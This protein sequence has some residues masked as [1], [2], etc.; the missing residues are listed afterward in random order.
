LKGDTFE[1]KKPLKSGIFTLLMENFKR[2]V[3]G[4]NQFMK[5]KIFVA[6]ALLAS[7]ISFAQQKQQNAP[8][9]PPPIM[10]NIPPPQAPEAPP[11]PAIQFEKAPLPD[12]GAYKAFLKRNPTVKGI[13]W[14]DKNAVRIY[15]KSGKEEVYDL[16]NPEEAQRLKKKYGELP[17]APPAPPTP[18]TPPKLPEA[19]K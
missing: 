2:S 1:N 4:R 12:N 15:L 3:L 18:P 9:P 10:D 19:S 16:N 5:K 6:T 11:P 8:P 14:S 13:A 17:T 7:I